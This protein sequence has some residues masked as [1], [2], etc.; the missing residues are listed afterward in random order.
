MWIN[1]GCYKLIPTHAYYHHLNYMCHFSGSRVFTPVSE[2]DYMVMETMMEMY[3]PER[4]SVGVK[5]HYNREKWVSTLGS[6]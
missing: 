6:N 5:K 3:Q 1:N 2:R 4:L